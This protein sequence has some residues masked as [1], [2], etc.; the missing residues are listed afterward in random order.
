[1]NPL[2]TI[3]TLGIDAE[4]QQWFDEQR[5]LYF[6]PAMNHIGAHLTLFHALPGDGSVRHVLAEAA[7]GSRGFAMQT[8]GVRSMGRGVMYLLEAPELMRLHRGLAEK[9]R[10]F[11]IPQ[12][13]QP[14]KPH[15]V[16]QNKVEPA[17][18][19]A[20]LAV[21]QARFVARRV[22]AVGL[23]WWEYRGGPWRHMERFALGTAAEN[24]QED[25][26]EG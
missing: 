10:T 2:T 21:L 17:E 16:V 26:R 20:L 23:D 19:K 5:Q 4:S 11:L 14:L 25:A 24:G 3:V 18:A 7:A 22:E 9:F 15:V 8:V 1:M 13:K 6:P 12:D